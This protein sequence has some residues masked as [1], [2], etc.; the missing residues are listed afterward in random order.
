MGEELI[1]NDEALPLTRIRKM[2]PSFYSRVRKSPT[3]TKHFRLDNLWRSRKKE[4]H[5][6]SVINSSHLFLS[7]LVSCVDRL[8]LYIQSFH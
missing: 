7:S 6:Y 4:L 3:E 1:V 8:M 2:A 5:L